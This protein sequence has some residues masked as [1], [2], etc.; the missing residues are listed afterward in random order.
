MT[1]RQVALLLADLALILVLAKTVG[2]IARRLRQPAVIG[3]I[4]AGILVGP[5]LLHGEIAH[6]LFPLDVRPYL[7]ALADLGLVLFMFVVGI[8]FD[9]AK[10]RGRSRVTAATAIGSSLIPFGLGTLLA[11]YL[12]ADHQTTSKVG[13]FLF[14]GTAMSVTAFPVLARILSER[15]LASTLI[16]TIAM[17]A[18]AFCDIVAWSLLALVQVIVGN[19]HQPHWLI[20][21]LIPY[22][23]IMFLAVRPLLRRVLTTGPGGGVLTPRNFAI[24]LTGLLVSAAITQ[25]AGLH[26]IFGA[27]LFGLVMPRSATETLRVELIRRTEFGT[28]LLLPVYFVVTG[29][30]VDLS[31]LGASGGVELVL[32][33]LVAIAGKFGGAFLGARTQGLPNRPAATLA[34]L[35][36]TRGLTEL[37]ALTVGLQIGVLDKQLYSLMVVMAV[38][39]TTMSG[40]IINWLRPP[41]DPIVELDQLS[42]SRQESPP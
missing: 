37:V 5:T 29:F 15:G 35:M 6:T 20:L 19:D 30:N 38:V 7:T 2:M 23:L 3:E 14:I 32:I 18:A 16:G 39:T 17:S 41:T 25:F 8:E 40:P 42:T 9:H 24:V 36:N 1:D 27:F 10:L 22:L 28:T 33:I 34:T 21:L 31:H 4:V 26:F 13:F 12:I 11:L